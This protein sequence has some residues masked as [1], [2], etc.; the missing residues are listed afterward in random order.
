MEDDKSIMKEEKIRVWFY[1]GIP[2]QVIV[3]LVDS[4]YPSYQQLYEGMMKVRH[5]FHSLQGAGHF[6]QLIYWNL[7]PTALQSLS[8][9]TKENRWHFLCPCFQRWFEFPAEQQAC[10]LCPRTDIEV[11][12]VPDPDPV[13]QQSFSRDPLDSYQHL[14]YKLLTL[15]YINVIVPVRTTI[16]FFWCIVFIMSTH[17]KKICFIRRCIMIYL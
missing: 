14:K 13:C 11:S 16:K 12:F 7:C 9:K 5:Y 10:C 8:L 4:P 17:C 3:L 2:W 1:L 6:V 15:A